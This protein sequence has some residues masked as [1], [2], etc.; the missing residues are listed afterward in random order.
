MKPTD[1]IKLDKGMFLE[2]TYPPFTIMLGKKEET[3]H[4]VFNDIDEIHELN[5]ITTKLKEYLNG[6]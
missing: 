1:L 4:Y 3:V 6:N 2:P 5:T